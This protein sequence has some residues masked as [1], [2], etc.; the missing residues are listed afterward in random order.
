MKA[1]H[2]L[3]RGRHNATYGSMARH[4]ADMSDLDASWVTLFGGQDGWLGSENL[5]DQIA[6]WRERRSIRLPLRP[7]TVAR[8]FP[9]LTRLAPR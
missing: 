1:A 7:E 6:L 2:G 5:T 9:I 8:E 4:V 3:V